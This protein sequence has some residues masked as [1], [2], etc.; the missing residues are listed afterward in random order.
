LYRGAQEALTNVARH[1]PGAHALVVLRYE[2][3]RTRL[4]VTNLNGSDPFTF[5]G[6]G[7]GFGLA[8][9]R[10]RVAQAGGRVEAGPD[11]DEF[12]VELEFSQ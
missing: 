7:G 11:G 2:P 10:D 1:A 8:G 3:E 6:D 9:M 4:T 12:R 5:G